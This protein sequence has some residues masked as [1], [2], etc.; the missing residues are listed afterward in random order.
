[1]PSF[2]YKPL[3][4]N[5]QP[6]PPLPLR[7]LLNSESLPVIASNKPRLGVGVIDERNTFNLVGPDPRSGLSGR[8]GNGPYIFR[9]WVELF[10]RRRPAGPTRQSRLLPCGSSSRLPS[11]FTSFT[12][13][14]SL[15]LLLS[16]PLR[17]LPRGLCLAACGSSLSFSPTGHCSRVTGHCCEATATWEESHSAMME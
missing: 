2:F 14:T 3:A 7:G 6:I 4:T 5:H 12:S 1:M 16:L 8:S 10:L 9:P 15:T 11:P 17:A 13:A